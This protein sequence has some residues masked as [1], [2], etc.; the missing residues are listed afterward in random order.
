MDSHDLLIYFGGAV[1]ALAKP[2]I[3]LFNDVD[4]AGKAVVGGYSVRFDDEG[5]ARDL[6]GNWF[7]SNT[8]FGAHEGDG[9]D[10]VFHHT[11]PVTAK[12]LKAETALSLADH[13]FQPAKATKDELGIWVE[14]VLDLADDYEKFV[15]QLA[16][17][18]K[19]GWSSGTSLHLARVRT[20]AGKSVRYPRAGAL[21]RWPIIEHSLTPTPSEPRNR[22]LPI[23]AFLGIES[24]ESAIKAMN[25]SRTVSGVHEA[26]RLL[27][28][29]EY[30]RDAYCIEVWDEFVVAR[31]DGSFYKIPYKMSDDEMK[32]A[33]REDWAIVK[34]KREWIEVKS[35]YALQFDE[36]R[37]QQ[38]DRPKTGESTPVEQPAG[39]ESVAAALLR[40]LEQLHAMLPS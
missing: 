19:L 31:L 25:L 28:D 36:F 17:A 18:G 10:V 21:D 11:I 23:K 1:K 30:K 3:R 29:P 34:E 22:A 13:L 14:A 33:G 2:E 27:F 12:G 6:D 32:F 26:F 15:S 8:Y 38:A 20:A 40:D 5:Q 4:L 39:G 16:E 37:R 9:C 7:T 35:L 24:E